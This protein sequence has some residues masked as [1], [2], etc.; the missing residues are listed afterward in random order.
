MRIIGRL[1]IV[2]VAALGAAALGIY[3]FASRI[4]ASYQPAQLSPDQRTTSAKGFTARVLNEFGNKIQVPKSFTWS[5]TQEELNHYLA[6]MDEIAEL[7]PNSRPGLVRRQLD[8]VGLSGPAVALEKN[9][10]TVMIRSTHYEKILSADLAFTFPAEGRL[11][12]QVAG[13]RLGALPVPQSMLQ[14]RLADLRTL[15]AAALPAKAETESPKRISIEHV[16]RM[17]S[18]VILAV[19]QEPISTELPWRVNGRI[20]RIDGIDIEHERITLRV[21]PVSNPASQPQHGSQP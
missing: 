7:M 10:L 4:P 16:G 13:A 17:L 21:T 14:A 5:A 20:I 12:V 19:G 9:I 6:S 18:H 1:L 2:L 8:E 11:A 3:L 15:L